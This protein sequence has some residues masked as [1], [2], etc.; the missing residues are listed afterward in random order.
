MH[1]EQV[2][3]RSKH[4]LGPLVVLLGVYQVPHISQHV[5]G[6]LGLLEGGLHLAGLETALAL[7]VEVVEH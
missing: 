1:H 4:G 3:G 6:Q 5:F 2:E 7:L